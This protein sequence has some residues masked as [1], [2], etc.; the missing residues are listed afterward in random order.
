MRGHLRV[1]ASINRWACIG[2]ER[3]PGVRGPAG[4]A[5]LVGV[6]S[7]GAAAASLE[8]CSP[9]GSLQGMCGDAGYAANDGCTAAAQLPHSPHAPWAIILSHGKACIASVTSSPCSPPSSAATLQHPE[10]PGI[11]PPPPAP[12]P[13]RGCSSGVRHS[14]SPPRPP[15]TL[16]A[17]LQPPQQRR[18]GDVSCQVL[19]DLG[20]RQ[21]KG[22][23]VRGH[24][25]QQDSGGGRLQGA[26]HRTLH[27]APGM[28]WKIIVRGF[29]WVLDQV[30]HL[31]ACNA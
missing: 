29:G 1:N 3:V 26:Q 11:A 20:N 4:K 21:G 24:A 6:L 10:N 2:A 5:G 7:L 13:L 15:R 28:F 25:P 17:H 9:R 27:T 30:Q 31:P 22:A 23:E 19:H 12:P 16:Q 8:R 14:P 18:G